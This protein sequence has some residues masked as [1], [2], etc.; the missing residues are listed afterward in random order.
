MT[1]NAGKLFAKTSLVSTG[2]TLSNTNGAQL[3]GDSV[4]L[5]ATNLITRSGLIESNPTL[6]L[7]GGSLENTSGQLR[8]LGNV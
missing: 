7:Q 1:S 4:N 8:A 6:N 5:T 3:S 2:T